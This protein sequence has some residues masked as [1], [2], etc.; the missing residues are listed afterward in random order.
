VAD[1]LAIPLLT[2]QLIVLHK[3]NEPMSNQDTKATQQLE[4]TIQTETTSD[5]AY[6][7]TARPLWEL[8]VEIGAQVPDEEWAK[9]PSDLSKNVDH[10]LYGAPKDDE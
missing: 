2:I 7:S 1:N 8:V 6:D 3:E 9:V 10:Y 5:T 4:E